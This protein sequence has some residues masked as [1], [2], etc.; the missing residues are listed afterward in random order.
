VVDLPGLRQGRSGGTGRAV[1]LGG[2]G[3]EQDGLWRGRCGGAGASAR[4][5]R[6]LTP[7]EWDELVRLI[8]SSKLVPNLQRIFLFWD[9]S[10]LIDFQPNTVKTRKAGALTPRP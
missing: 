2:K 6:G 3:A 7:C 4:R 1:A 10:I 8:L 5:R 9:G